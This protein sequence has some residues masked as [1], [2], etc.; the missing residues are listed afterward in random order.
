MRRRESL[1][2]AA[3]YFFHHEGYRVT[4]GDIAERAGVT[5]RTLYRYMGTKQTMLFE[6][7]LAAHAWSVP[8][9]LSTVEPIRE[10]L[11]VLI[12]AHAE[13]VAGMHEAMM[14]W[15]EE[16]KYLSDGQRDEVRKSQ[17][18]HVQAY[19]DVIAAG[20]DE[21]QFR[22][23]NR[24]IVARSIHGAVCNLARWYQPRGAL[25]ATALGHEIATLLI[26]GIGRREP[27][28]RGM[29]G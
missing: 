11:T 13:A 4:T 24:S 16:A 7:C 19:Q 18:A 9:G 27:S 20:I 28:S 2:E 6:V 1:L 14:V 12:T 26:E 22:A 21:G 10:R 5:K 8:E 17:A 3:A 15:F 25:A 29:T 23:C